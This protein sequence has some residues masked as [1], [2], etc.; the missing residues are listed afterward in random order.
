MKFPGLMSGV[1]GSL[2]QKG[3]WISLGMTVLGGNSYRESPISLFSLGSRFRFVGRLQVIRAGITG[4]TGGSRVSGISL[5]TFGSIDSYTRET[6]L[7]L[8]SNQSI[9]SLE[10]KSRC[11][12][13]T[14]TGDKY[15]PLPAVKLTKDQMTNQL[16]SL[17]KLLT[18]GPS[19]PGSPGKPAGPSLPGGPYKYTDCINTSSNWIQQSTHHPTE[20][21]IHNW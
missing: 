14:S 7:T 8:H 11:E 2:L 12:R 9:I 20:S 1:R 5:V 19:G 13:S 17:K 15:W 4:G 10:N 21:T 18:L 6:F 16:H 3:L